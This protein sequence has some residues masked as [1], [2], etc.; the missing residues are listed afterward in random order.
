M[1]IPFQPARS[2]PLYHEDMLIVKLRPTATAPLTA[3]TTL[4]AAALPLA[5]SPGLSALAVYERA[6]LIK[7]VTPLGQQRASPMATGLRPTFAALALTT[8]ET[9]KPSPNAGTAIIELHPGTNL[10]Q[11][12]LSMASDMVVEAVS[13]VPIRYLLARSRADR[14][15]HARAGGAAPAAVPPAAETMWNLRKIQWRDARTGG[16][17]PAKLIRVAVLDTG[18]DLTHPD[19]PGDDITYVHDYTDSGASASDQDIIGHGTHVSGTIRAII[20]NDIGINGICECK[21]SVYKIFPDTPDP[22][23]GRYYVDPILYHSALATCADAN[24]QVINLSI[25]G[26][27]EPDFQ[28]KQ[29]FNHLIS[30]GVTVVAAMGNEN[31]TIPS[32]PAALPGVVAVGA[33]DLDDTRANF[34]NMGPHITLSAPGVGIWSTLPTYPGQV[35]AG[36]P[37]DTD[38]DA[39]AGTS[40]ATPHVTA[41]AACAAAMKSGLS[42]ADMMALLM[43]AVDKVD[44][45]AGEDFTNEFGAGRLNLM[46]LLSVLQQ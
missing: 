18:V 5:T 17:D 24:I 4:S 40:M 44:D 2:E 29:L 13:R 9:G 33:T 15:T 28:E 25:G 45:M 6:G 1:F 21:L 41:A 19:L 26:R 14:G 43:Q 10:T 22:L 36:R 34:S 11:L 42:P 12:Q 46:K 8:A 3:A 38:Y 23:S 37:R 7:R 31:S 35:E 39:W 32:Y 27:G 30:S 20:D 16:L